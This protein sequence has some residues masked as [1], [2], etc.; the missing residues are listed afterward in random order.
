MRER[1]VA[2]HSLE[3][4]DVDRFIVTDSPEEAVELITQTALARFGL[5][6]GAAPGG[7]GSW[8]SSANEDRGGGSGRDQARL[9]RAGF[10]ARFGAAV[11]RRA[12]RFGAAAG[13]AWAAG[14]AAAATLTTAGRAG[15]ILCSHTVPS[16]MWLPFRRIRSLHLGHVPINISLARESSRSSSAAAREYTPAREDA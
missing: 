15:Q 2:E 1:L 8:A 3:P 4:E 5:T 13:W 14:F 16:L 11:A 7:G 12:T 10:A 6:S 9:A